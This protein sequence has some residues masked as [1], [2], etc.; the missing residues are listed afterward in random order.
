MSGLTDALEAIRAFVASGG[1]VLIAIAILTLLMWTLIFERVWYFKF[2]LSRDVRAALNAWEGR[3]E[4]QSWNAHQVRY[5]L[6]SRVEEKINTNLDMIG[7]FV[8]LAPLFGLLGTVWGMIEV[9][10]VLAVTG[11]GDAKSMASGVSKATIPTMAGMVAALSGVF[12]N[13]YVTRIAEREN[14]LFA[15]HLTMDH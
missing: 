15:D 11:G 6:I 10:N 14:Q 7:T 3:S 12:G 5:A 8:A 13:T 9:F 2:M 1:E 4:R